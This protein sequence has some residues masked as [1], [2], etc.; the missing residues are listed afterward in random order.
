MGRKKSERP[1]TR[2]TYSLEYVDKLKELKERLAP[3]GLHITDGQAIDVLVATMH[4]LVIEKRGI[5]CDPD[6]M[7]DVL[8]HHFTREFS[9]FLAQAL[10]EFGHKDVKTQW[11]KDG[12]V[13]VTCDGAAADIPAKVFAGERMD[14]DGLLRELK[15]GLPC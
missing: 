7:L 14:K 8:N 12:S 2:N 15:T 13:I 9:K 4:E 3:K 6:K 5:I 1:K 11:R 10:E